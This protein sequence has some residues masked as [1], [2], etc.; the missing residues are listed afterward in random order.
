MRYTKMYA[1]RQP[2]GQNRGRRAT[3]AAMGRR[4]LDA[5]K[6]AELGQP[7]GRLIQ[8]SK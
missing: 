4:V 3:F 2:R 6:S 8:L 5:W 7:M 1:T